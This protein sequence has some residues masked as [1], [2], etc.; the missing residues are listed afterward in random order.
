MATGV[1]PRTEAYRSKMR[2]SMSG[3]TV[4]SETRRKLSLAN[5]GKTHTEETRRK[6]SLVLKGRKLSEESN[7]EKSLRM[8]GHSV[9]EETRKKISIGHTGMKKPWTVPP[10]SKSGIENPMW[11][12]DK[13]GYGGLHMWVAHYLG[14]P[15]TCEHCGKSGLTGK[16]INWANKSHHYLRELTDWLRL[17]VPC[18]RAYDQK[19]I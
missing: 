6:L 7:R 4:S 17:C 3:H 16:H 18:H 11:K 8:M 9:S 12:G 10:L 19:T 2:A 5:T 13:V 15:D 1:Y 14:K